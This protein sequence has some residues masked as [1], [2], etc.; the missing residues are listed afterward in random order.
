MSSP[1]GQ[2]FRLC[3]RCGAWSSDGVQDCRQCGETL[4]TDRV[5]DISF[6]LSFAAET[7]AAC[8]ET[9]PPG[10]CPGCG[11]EIPPS[12]KIDEAASARGAAFLPLLERAESVLARYDELPEPHIPVAADQY[13]ATLADGRLFK[14]LRVS[15]RVPER[16]GRFDLDDTKQIGGRVRVLLYAYVGEFERIYAEAEAGSDY[17]YVWADGIHLRT[18]NPIESTFATIRLRQ[19]VDPAP[20]L[21]ASP[22]PSSSSS[23]P[24]A[25]GAPSTHPTSSPSSAPAPTKA[26]SSNDPTTNLTTSQE[27][28]LKPRERSICGWLTRSAR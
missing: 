24:N 11:A 27:M 20:A 25:A 26:A 5:F 4:E 15:L 17:V 3:Q 14:R 9:A 28:T 2:P 21:P 23:P 1:T 13:A 12:N 7:C 10:T 18:T 8:G 22:W 6:T 16:L 19:R